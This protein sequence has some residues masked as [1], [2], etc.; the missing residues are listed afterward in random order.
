MKIFMSL[1]ALIGL[2][3]CA[4]GNYNRSYIISHTSEQISEEVH[5]AEEL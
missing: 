5:E 3:G 1:L 2:T 4:T